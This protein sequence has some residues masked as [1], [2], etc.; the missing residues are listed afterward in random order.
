MP[1]APANQKSAPV[2]SV[3][4]MQERS[5]SVMAQIDV[6][7]NRITLLREVARHQKDVIKLNCVNDKIVELKAQQNIADNA[8]QAMGVLDANNDARQSAFDGLTT[9]GAAIHQ[10]GEQAK[11]CVGQPELYKQESGNE[12][13]R[14]PTPDDPTRDPSRPDG[15]GLE[16]PAYSSPYS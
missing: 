3:K 5:H 1:S 15:W 13:D 14:P 8:N 16:P 6:D 4:D 2:M 7:A 9:A 12:V 10:L 11:G